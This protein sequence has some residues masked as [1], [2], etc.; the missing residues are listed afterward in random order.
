M[1]PGSKSGLE[2]GIQCRLPSYAFKLLF[3]FASARLG[4][5]PSTLTLEELDA[6]LAIAFLAHLPCVFDLRTMRESETIA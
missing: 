5:S 6:P 2:I 4:S 1:A 3:D